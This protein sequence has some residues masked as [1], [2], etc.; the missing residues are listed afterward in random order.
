MCYFTNDVEQVRIISTDARL[1][2][3]KLEG[4]DNS[5]N[6]VVSNCIERIV[7][8]E[9]SAEEYQQLDLG[10]YLVRGTNVVCVGEV[11]ETDVNWPEVVGHKLKGTKNPL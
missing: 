3:G 1:F 10:V 5:T 8:V 9:G 7:K 2:E 11:D 6:I 4:Y